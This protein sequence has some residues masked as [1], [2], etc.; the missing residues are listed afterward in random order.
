M[1]KMTVQLYPTHR[2]AWNNLGGQQVI[3]PFSQHPKK[4]I[5]VSSAWRVFFYTATFNSITA[6]GIFRSASHINMD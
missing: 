6:K 3:S 5:T 2:C 4:S 1:V